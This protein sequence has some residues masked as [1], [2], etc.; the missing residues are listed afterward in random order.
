MQLL[1]RV[2]RVILKMSG[3]SKQKA[4]ISIILIFALSFA[5][6]IQA[7]AATEIRAPAG[8]Q[9]YSFT[10]DIEVNE[11]VPYAGI[12]F[13]L[14]LSDENAL[15]FVSFTQGDSI[16][17]ATAYPFIYSHGIH[18]FGFWTGTNAYQ[19]NI[20][21][22]TLNFTYTG[23][24]PQTIT[25]NEMMIVRIDGNKADGTYKTSPIQVIEVSRETGNTGG[26]IP[27]GDIPSG[28]LPTNTTIVIEEEEL[29]LAG[30]EIK[31]KYFDDV[32]E[33]KWPWAVNE[34]DYLYEQGV[35]NGMGARIYSPA[36]NITRG[37]FTLMLV[38]AYG[39][40]GAFE[41]NFAD[42]PQGSYYYDA[43]GVA[44]KLGIV[45]G[46]GDNK[47]APN[48]PITRQDMMV[49]IERI[50]KAV[51]KP[52]PAAPPSVLT[53]FSDHAKISYYARDSVAALVQSGIVKGDGQNINPINYTTRADMAVV[54]YRILTM[55]Q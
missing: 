42:V 41:D 19:G 22:G 33:E 27:G 9:S 44:K 25:I 28:D 51:G 15:T 31:S 45:Q 24:S 6:S 20:K 40:F 37:D 13:G 52:V 14:T 18:S 54:V 53:S 48:L 47:F 36:Q 38:R 43:I 16:G 39:L 8:N 7:F 11:I 3:A 17:G 10:V 21:V 35:I 50:L 12:Q 5:I 46:V 34:I 26:G 23:S 29:P 4:I 49:L 55:D 32:P 2:R 1:Y 30:V